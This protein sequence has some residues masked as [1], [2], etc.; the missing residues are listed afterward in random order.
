[1]FYFHNFHWQ[2]KVECIRFIF[3]TNYY[4]SWDFAQYPLDENK[5]GCLGSS[6][7][8]TPFTTD[9]RE[10]LQILQ[11]T[12]SR[13]QISSYRGTPLRTV[14][15]SLM[16]GGSRFELGRWCRRENQAWETL[17]LIGGKN[18]DLHAC[19]NERSPAYV[20]K[21]LEIRIL[22]CN[23]LNGDSSCDENDSLHLLPLLTAP[24][25]LISDKFPSPRT[26][27]HFHRKLASCSC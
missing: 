25:G 26:R 4:K 7:L 9:S 20:K 18:S 22:D 12:I 2:P 24:R 1:M 19:F 8:G 3:W 6:F 5:G 17:L 27:A 16:P 23:C 21:N 11:A 10:N 13:K 15:V 14:H